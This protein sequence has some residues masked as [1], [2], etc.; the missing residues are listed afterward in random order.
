MVKLKLLKGPE[1]HHSELRQ[2][3]ETERTN[4]QISEQRKGLLATNRGDGLYPG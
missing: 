1:V 4:C 3:P 2:M